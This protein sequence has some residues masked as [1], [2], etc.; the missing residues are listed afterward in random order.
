MKRI[1][2]FGVLPSWTGLIG[3]DNRHSGVDLPYKFVWFASDD[4]TARR[5]R[6]A[7]IRHRQIFLEIRAG[8]DMKCKTHRLPTAA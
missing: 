5:A 4:R 7:R 6:F 1:G 8:S 3:Q 2:R